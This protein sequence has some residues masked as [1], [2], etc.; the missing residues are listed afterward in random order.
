MDH[1]QTS[2][3]NQDETEDG[4]PDVYGDSPPVDDYRLGCGP[5]GDATS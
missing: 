1:E 5:A 2:D 4:W 3:G